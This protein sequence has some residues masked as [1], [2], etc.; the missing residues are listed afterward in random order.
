MSQRQD[1]FDRSIG[2]HDP[3]LLRDEIRPLAQSLLELLV[4]PV[5]ILRMDP[6]QYRFA[7]RRTLL[8]IEAPDAEILL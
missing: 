3:V 6:L 4:H 7:V 5:A 2:Q 8:G 1:V